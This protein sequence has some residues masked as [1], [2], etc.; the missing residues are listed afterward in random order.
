MFPLFLKLFASSSTFL[1]S[2]FSA[3]F[4]LFFQEFFETFQ[5]LGIFVDFDTFGDKYNRNSNVDQYD[6]VK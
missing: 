4:F 3:V 6:S 2:F 5:G 1:F